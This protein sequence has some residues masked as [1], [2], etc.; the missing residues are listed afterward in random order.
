MDKKSFEKICEIIQKYR[1]MNYAEI[2]VHNG[3]TASGICREILKYNPN[4]HFV[5]YDAFTEVPAVEHNGKSVSTNSHYEKCL[6]RFNGLKNENKNFTWNLIKG[7]TTNTLIT[8][9]K[10]DFV[11]IDGGHSYDTVMHDY[12]MVKESK[13]ILF[14]DYKLPEVKRAVNDIGKGELFAS[15]DTWK[16]ATWIIIN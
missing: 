16:K 9:V 2:G 14:D 5:G 10:Y 8:P 15:Y 3:L 12:S 6:W 7:F 1:P 11:Y 13:I 4:L